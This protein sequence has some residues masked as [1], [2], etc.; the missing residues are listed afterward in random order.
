[1]E[2][3]MK[4]KILIMIN[5]EIITKYFWLGYT[6]LRNQKWL[7]IIVTQNIKN[8]YENWSKY[9]IYFLNNFLVG[10]KKKRK[11]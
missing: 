3:K 11:I 2:N 6:I 10:K 5:M 1:M 9:L 8:I 7:V 4:N